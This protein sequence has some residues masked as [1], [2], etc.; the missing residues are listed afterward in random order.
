MKCSLPQATTFICSIF[1][2]NSVLEKLELFSS[3]FPW[4]C[5]EADAGIDD[6]QILFVKIGAWMYV[7]WSAKQQL[8]SSDSVKVPAWLDWR[9]EGVPFAVLAPAVAGL[10]KEGRD[11]QHCFRQHVL[12]SQVLD[13]EKIMGMTEGAENAKCLLIKN[14]PDL[15]VLHHS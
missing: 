8:T 1:K 6:Y 12:V 13:A 3:L 7:S 15:I 4:R 14:L 5:R 2:E 11:S 9:Q 10:S